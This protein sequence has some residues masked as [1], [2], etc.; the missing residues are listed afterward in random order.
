MVKFVRSL[1]LASF[2]AGALLV[3]GLG[4]DAA[5]QVKTKVKEAAPAKAAAAGTLEIYEG[6]DGWRYRVKNADGKVVAMPPKGLS[7]KEDLMKELDLIKATLRDSK[8]TEVK[9]E[10]KME[11]KAEKK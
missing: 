2:A 11:K 9:G 10:T 6:K 5:A 1:G 8:P 4:S 3:A 7:S